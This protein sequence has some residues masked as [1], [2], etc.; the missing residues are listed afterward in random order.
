MITC[1]VLPAADVG[2]AYRFNA[3]SSSWVQLLDWIPR[4]KYTWY[5]VEALAVHLAR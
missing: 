2:G 1:G 3:S 5:G 4:E